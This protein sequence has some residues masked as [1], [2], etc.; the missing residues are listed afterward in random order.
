MSKRDYYEVLGVSQTASEQEIKSAYRRLA[1]K[2]HPDKN[3][4]D[5]AAEESFKEAAEAYSVLSDAE[6]RRRYDRFGHAGVS[7]NAGAGGWGAPGFGGI[8]DILG[9]LFGFGDV[10]GA[11]G[12]GGRRNAAQRGAD[13]RYDLEISLEDAAAGM[14]AQLRIP[15]LETCDKC[16]GSGASEGTQPETCQTCNGAGQ[17]RYQQGFFSV[18]RTCGTCRGTG[19]VVKSPC[20]ACKGAGRVEREKNM[21]VKIPAGV[22][23]GS[24]LRIAGEGEAGTQG[25]TT[26]DLYVVIHVSEHE[27]FERQG[28]NLYSSVPVTFAQAAL[29]A[30]IPVQTLNGQQQVKIPAGTQ[31]GTVFRLKGH[32]VPVLGG[33]GRGDLFVSVT[34]VT[35][36]TLTRE[37]RRIL[38]Q[39]SEVETKDL[40]DKGLIDKV[41]NIFG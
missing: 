19:S 2:F 3:P 25:G 18:A 14:T 11:R 17:V 8:E 31:T 38:E 36:T 21:E 27:H 40:E 7:S 5:A 12:A 6:Q 34:V 37:Q 10:F 28:S 16:K 35:P 33:R 24:R 1:V 20:D 15:R 30:E 4:G 9:D 26:G 22:E 23:T 39:L 13:L 32:G 41:R 29:G